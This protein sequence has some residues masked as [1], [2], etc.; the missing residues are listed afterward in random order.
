VAPRPAPPAV[1]GAARSPRIVERLLALDLVRSARGVA[2]FWPMEERHEVD[3][4]ALDVRLR[5]RGVRLAYPSV[6]AETE[7]MTFRF[8][9]N[10]SA[11][12][13]RALGFH[14][15][16]PLEPEALPSE[17]DVIIAPALAADPAGQRIGYG[18][19]YYDKALPLFAPPAS[20][21]AVLFDFQL[22]AESPVTAGDVPAGWIVTDARTLQ[23]QRE[24]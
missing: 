16:S 1:A 21:V 8:V 22:I 11:M 14:E 4:R 6:D 15:P 23:A 12:Q 2:L 24:V 13:P 17:I 3:L 20:T 7:A 10:P 18:G 5:E 9:T 19:G